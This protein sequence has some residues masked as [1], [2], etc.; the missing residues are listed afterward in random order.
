ML[1]GGGSFIFYVSQDSE[2]PMVYLEDDYSYLETGKEIPETTATALYKKYIGSDKVRKR[3]YNG[4][5]KQHRNKS[6]INRISPAMIEVMAKAQSK[7]SVDSMA[8]VP[9]KVDGKDT[10]HKFDAILAVYAGGERI[11]DSTIKAM[12]SFKTFYYVNDERSPTCPIEF[13]NADYRDPPWH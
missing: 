12:E 8:I 4:I 7:Y 10:T 3:T 5:K 1:I 13:D 11:N 9:G 6:R 2:E